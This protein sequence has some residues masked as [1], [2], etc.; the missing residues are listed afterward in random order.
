MCIRVVT[1]GRGSG[2]GS[3][4]SVYVH[5]MRGEYDSRILWPFR[6]DITIQLV[7]H[8]SNINHHEWTVYFG[9]AADGRRVTSREKADYGRGCN[10][11]I[12]HTTVES[13]T[14]TSRYIVDDCLTFRITRIV[15]H[16]V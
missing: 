15:V 11:F 3:H 14:V 9:D 13:S 12:S 4:V 10:Q 2:A 16:S 1:N 6:G 5:L 7:N 8:N